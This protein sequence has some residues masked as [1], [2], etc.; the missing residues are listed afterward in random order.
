[1]LDKRPVKIH[2][3]LYLCCFNVFCHNAELYQIFEEIE[4]QK[5]E[6]EG[7]QIG[8]HTE[9]LVI[10]KRKAQATRKAFHNC[11][12]HTQANYAPAKEQPTLFTYNITANLAYHSKSQ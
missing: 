6:K 1:M 3:W 7:F 5:A 8:L 11:D 4:S 10:E 2:C 9:I 12:Y